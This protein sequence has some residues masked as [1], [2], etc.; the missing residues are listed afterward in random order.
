MKDYSEHTERIIAALLQRTGAGQ[1]APGG[2]QEVPWESLHL[3]EIDG[4]A[5]RGLL[6]LRLLPAAREVADAILAEHLLARRLEGY[7][8]D[9]LNRG[10]RVRPVAG[11]RDDLVGGIRTRVWEGASE[12]LFSC[13]PSMAALFPASLPAPG[14]SC[15]AALV[16]HAGEAFPGSMRLTRIDDTVWSLD[17]SGS[18]LPV[19]LSSLPDGRM[20]VR[21]APGATRRKATLAIPVRLSTDDCGT[22]VESIQAWGYTLDESPLRVAWRR[23]PAGIAVIV[24]RTR[25]DEVGPQ[26]LHPPHPAHRSEANDRVTILRQS[27]P[28]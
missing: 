6:R 7:L 4:L 24:E 26:S 15:D 13:S 8:A 28:R 9:L 27:P 21:E 22:V 20:L 14:G 5:D 3:V 18:R 16:L 2:T 19:G 10:V 25:P 23:V 11:S 12:V 17:I 1:N